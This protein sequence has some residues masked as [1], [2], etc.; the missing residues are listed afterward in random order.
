MFGNLGSLAARNVH[1]TEANLWDVGTLW[2]Y[3]DGGASFY[4]PLLLW[5]PRTGG[6]GPCPPCPGPKTTKAGRGSSSPFPGPRSGL[7]EI[8]PRASS[9]LD[10]ELNPP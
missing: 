10:I 9:P 6:P 3:P 8:S 4:H 2:Q 1:V 5:G 7:T